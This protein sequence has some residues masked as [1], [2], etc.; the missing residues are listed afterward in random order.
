MPAPSVEDPEADRSPPGRGATF[1]LLDR[2]IDVGRGEA[3]FSYDHDGE[4]FRE[5][6]RFPPG[7]D[8]GDAD[9]LRELL[10]LCH[11][12]I[13][14][15]YFKLRAPTRLVVTQPVSAALLEVCRQTYDQGL[16]ELAVTNGLELPLAT[17]I[18]AEVTG[19][20]ESRPLPLLT[21][22]R[23]LVPV[24]GGKDSAAVLGLLPGAAGISVSATAVQRKLAAAAGVELLEVDRVID[25]ELFRLTPSG[26][27]GHIPITAINSAVS[28]LVAHLFGYDCVVMGN[29][30]SASEPTRIVG[31]VAVNHQYSK[32]FEYETALHDALA[33]T[34]VNYFSLLRQLSELSIAGLVSRDPRLRGSF[35]SCNRAFVRA[36]DPEQPQAWCL[37][38]P[39]C[40][41]TFL[42]FAPYLTLEEADEVFGGNPLRDVARLEAFRD[43]WRPDAK[44]FDC[45]GERMESAAA[46]TWLGRRPGWSGLPVVRALAEDAQA[47]ATGFGADVASVLAVG[48]PHLIPPELLALVTDAVRR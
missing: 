18:E 42:C 47:T 32:S 28:S 25:P 27:N 15:S 43:L 33:P 30:R 2:T 1:A 23:P 26:F 29:E 14:T 4:V 40:L 9:A 48:G 24:G 7:G 21:C 36:R 12:V 6:L 44:P 31:G 22:G 38:C 19:G 20:S 10:D 11:V 45:V 17:E 8:P 5:A 41:F 34:G 16:R 37:E 35:L 39:K 13:G 3:T 46:M